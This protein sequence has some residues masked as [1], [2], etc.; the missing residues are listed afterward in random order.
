MCGGESDVKRQTID[1]G[2]T[3]LAEGGREGLG[4]VLRREKQESEPST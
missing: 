1:D 2:D 4:L 3:Y